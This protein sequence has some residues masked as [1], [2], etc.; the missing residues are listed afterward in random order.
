MQ[1]CEGNGPSIYF[2]KFRPVWGFDEKN[3]RR[4]P[5]DVRRTAPLFL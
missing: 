3:V 2:W 5:C 4:S 1:L